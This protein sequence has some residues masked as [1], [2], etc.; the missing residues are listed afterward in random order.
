MTI[1]LA[2][3]IISSVFQNEIA[4]EDLEFSKKDFKLRFKNESYCIDYYIFIGDYFGKKIEI[5]SEFQVR[6]SILLNF[7]KSYNIPVQEWDQVAIGE[8]TMEIF[9]S[10]NN[11][12]QKGPVR[13]LVIKDNKF[14]EN[15][16]TLAYEVIKKILFVHSK[17][18]FELNSNLKTDFDSKNNKILKF[19]LFDSIV[20][21]HYFK[22]DKLNAVLLENKSNFFDGGF[23]KAVYER[24]VL[25]L[26]NICELNNL[27]YDQYEPKLSFFQKIKYKFSD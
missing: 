3:K 18:K 20:L 1:K 24:Y 21:L 23:N 12:K 7:Y 25:L 17:I 9:N 2:K 19:N 10:F 27:D 11:T 22:P 14:E 13:F 6:L 5:F 4:N 15:V 8:N 16:T 26:K